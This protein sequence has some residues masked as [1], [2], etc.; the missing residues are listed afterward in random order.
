MNHRDILQTLNAVLPEVVRTGDAEGVLLKRAMQDDMSAAQ[1]ERL[2]QIFNAAKTVTVMNKY[3]SDR[4]R[5]FALVDPADV[6]SRYSTL[7]K[8]AASLASPAARSAPRSAA[9]D[10]VP[11]ISWDMEKGASF[12]QTKQASAATGAAPTHYEKLLEHRAWRDEVAS[13]RQEAEFLTEIGHGASDDCTVKVAEFI[14]RNFGAAYAEPELF[15]RVE[16]DFLGLAVG[17][18]A[19]KRAFIE[20]V[21]THASERLGQPVERCKSA[22]AFATDHTGQAGTLVAAWDNLCMI[23]AAR[24]L[25]VEKSARLGALMEKEPETKTDAD[26]ESQRSAE[27]KTQG[28]SS[29]ATKPDDDEGSPEQLDRDVYSLTNG[30]K[31]PMDAKDIA[32][33]ILEMQQGVGNRSLE[34]AKIVQ[35]H[36]PDA[37]RELV[38][39]GLGK[40]DAQ[41]ADKTDRAVYRDSVS[42]ALQQLQVSDPVISKAAPDTVESLAA[43]IMQAAPS[44][45]RDKNMLRLVLREAV[46]YGG[47]PI[48]TLKELA[49]LERKLQPAPA[50]GSNG[51]RT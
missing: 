20:M 5:A 46:Q 40:T 17:D 33:H 28:A 51:D 39:L 8:E 44:I 16:R 23:S 27:Q 19:E 35:E 3:A 43:T 47:V 48:H 25:L 36:F 4:G 15:A 12:A 26:I 24:A 18:E 41:I 14:E 45:A 9:L 34:L 38:S 31:T 50:G 21:A 11:V 30:S 1:L 37:Q 22:S 7:R 29:G 42:A 10:R 13:L 2:C 49:D 6:L 32:G